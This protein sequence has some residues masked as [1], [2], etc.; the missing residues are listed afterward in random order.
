MEQ[1]D[2]SDSTEENVARGMLGIRESRDRR[3]ETVTDALSR[4]RIR[5]S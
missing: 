3:A 1:S 4:S 2:P 5:G